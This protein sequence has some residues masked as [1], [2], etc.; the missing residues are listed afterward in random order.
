MGPI[1]CY[2][3]SLHIFSKKFLACKTA[4]MHSKL[5]TAIQDC[6]SVSI[7][8]AATFL[9]V[10]LFLDAYLCYITYLYLNRKIVLVIALTLN[11]LINSMSVRNRFREKS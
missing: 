9:L 11:K 1:S 3:N 2:H 10:S 5:K 4:K 8:Y 7:L 6:G